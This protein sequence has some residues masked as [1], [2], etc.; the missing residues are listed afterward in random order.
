MMKKTLLAT[1]LLAGSSAAIAE[2][3]GN[4]GLVSDYPFRGISQTSNSA[5]I[6]GGLDYGHDSGFYAGIWGSNVDFLVGNDLELDYYAGLG[7]D[8]TDGVAYD[9]GVVYYDYPGGDLGAGANDPEYLEVYAN[10]SGDVGPAGVTAS[11]YYSPDF[12]GETGDG[13]YVGLGAEFALTPAV[14][15][16]LSVGHQSIDEGKASDQGFFSSEEDSYVDWSVGLSTSV[17]GVDLGLTYT[18]TDLDSQA[19]C[20]GTDICDDSIWVSVGKSL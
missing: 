16:A 5:A 9:V 10:L 14:G 6:Q 18:D 1:A 13:I 4:V 17:G 15:L 2:I 3:T 19:D 12:F 7:G 11:L 8:V 20:F